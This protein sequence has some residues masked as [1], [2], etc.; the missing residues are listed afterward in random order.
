ME[1]KLNVCIVS[2]EFPPDTAFGG[3][4]TFSV[5]TALMLKQH[6]HRVTVLSQS[7]SHT[8]TFDYQGVTVWKLKVPWPFG[9]YRFLPALILGF[10][11]VVLRKLRRLHANAPFDLV[12]APDHLAEGLSA[13]LF[14]DLPVVTRLH[15]PFA[16][17]VDMGL[18][19]YR[20]GP[21][22]AFTRLAEKIAIARSDA[23]Y[24]PCLDLVRRCQTLFSLP[25]IPAKVFG[26][27]LDLDLFAPAAQPSPSDGSIRL[28]FLGRFEQRKG[29]ET[30]VGA[31][32]QIVAKR[33][34][35]K[36][37]MV[38]RDT[39]N[40]PG[41]SSA[42]EYIE[43]SLERA[44][45]LDHVEFRDYVP[46]EELPRI[47][48]EH[49]IVWVPSLYDNYPIVGLEGMACG[50][51]VVVADSGGLPEMVKDGV[52]GL[53]FQTGNADA[54]AARTLE[55]CE[56]PELSQRV[57]K[58]AREDTLAECSPE[59]IYGHSME[60][61]RY[62]LERAAADRRSRAAVANHS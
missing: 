33:P 31:L 27:P 30:I 2:R 5:D 25:R 39:P 43:R 45:C 9:T 29:I 20:K 50:K 58:A 41:Y 56:S 18:N 3:I 7:L 57:A 47:F 16:L 38:G 15:T 42:R 60:L 54:L 32:P 44:G 1:R 24:A 36:L 8:H 14:T 52:T 19:D 35:A 26:Y 6:G 11:Y 37:T 21:A 34:D 55:L 48:H 40:M 61:Y 49:D 13:A 10:N 28:L 46:L 17:L 4:G 53:V 23:V 51:P 12:D 59:S 22:Y 62:A